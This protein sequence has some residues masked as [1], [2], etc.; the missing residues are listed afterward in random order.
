MP[1]EGLHWIICDR[2]GMQYE[3][4]VRL[5]RRGTPRCEFCGADAV[6]KEPGEDREVPTRGRRRPLGRLLP[7]LIPGHH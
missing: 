7:R 6:V 1:Y 3:G 4:P 5:G 2:C